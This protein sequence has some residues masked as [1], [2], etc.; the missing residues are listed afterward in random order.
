M[1]DHVV[2]AE[3]ALDVARGTS[4]IASTEGKHHFLGVVAPELRTR[5]ERIALARP[6]TA[7][8]A[9]LTVKLLVEGDPHQRALQ[10]ATLG[11]V[12]LDVAERE[13]NAH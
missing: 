1:H 13:L 12:P 3:W 10:W 2:V 6:V 11:D 7:I 9:A 8:G 5:Y 4:T